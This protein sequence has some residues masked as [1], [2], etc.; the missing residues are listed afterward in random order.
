MPPAYLH[1]HTHTH[2]NRSPPFSL[3][4]PTK[5]LR[6]PPSVSSAPKTA[7]TPASDPWAETTAIKSIPCNNAETRDIPSLHVP[8]PLILP[9]NVHITPPILQNVSKTVPVPAKKPALPKLPALPARSW[10]RLVPLTP[11]TKNANATLV[12][13]MTIPMRRQQLR[14]M[15]PTG[16]AQAVPKPNT[17]ARKTPA[18]AT[19]PANAA[20]KPALLPVTPDQ[21]KNLNPAKN[22]VVMFVLQAQQHP[23]A[24]TGLISENQEQQ[25]AVQLVMC[26]ALLTLS[27]VLYG[28]SVAKIMA[29]K[30][31]YEP[32]EQIIITTV[33]LR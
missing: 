2:P 21:S 19:A 27:E 28:Q 26:A 11:I 12:P 3:N 7:A 30:D 16:A 5:P 22:A 32:Y 31:V 6:P 24:T 23:S 33:P 25:N 9:D 10:R 4:K 17:S 13:D 14:A 18:P 15:F 20:A 8:S 29:I 1:L